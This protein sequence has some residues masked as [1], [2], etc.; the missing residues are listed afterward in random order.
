MNKTQLNKLLESFKPNQDGD[1]TVPKTVW[2]VKIDGEFIR[3]LSGKTVWKKLGHAKNALN[4]HV[5]IWCSM[6]L[7]DDSNF[8]AKSIVNDWI[9]DGTIEF[10]ELET[11]TE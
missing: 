5:Q 10:I 2:R 8:D 9:K 11:V 1:L 4:Q 7:P 6:H 3:T